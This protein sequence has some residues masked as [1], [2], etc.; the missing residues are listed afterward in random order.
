MPVRD[1]RQIDLVGLEPA[2]QFSRRRTHD[3]HLDRRVRL[4][5]ALQDRGDIGKRIII[6]GA[7]ADRSGN[8][9]RAE[10]RQHLVVQRQNLPRPDQ[11]ILAVRRQF[12]SAALAAAEHRL[13]QHLLEALHL[14]GDGGLCPPHMGRSLGEAVALGNQHEGAQQVG[15]HCLGERHKHQII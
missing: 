9:R 14:H 8:L 6:R 1:Q 12:H 4:G 10:R 7:Q 15:V 2:H 13:A 11:Q 3:V 5:E